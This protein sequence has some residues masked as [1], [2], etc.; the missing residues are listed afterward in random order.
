MTVCAYDVR[1]GTATGEKTPENPQ[2]PLKVHQ[3]GAPGPESSGKSLKLHIQNTSMLLLGGRRAS[4]LESWGASGARMMGWCT[5]CSN[6][7]ACTFN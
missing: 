5:K 2:N 3:Q 1:A 6:G 7:A 4:L